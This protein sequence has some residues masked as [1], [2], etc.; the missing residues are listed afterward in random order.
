MPL[1]RVGAGT[2]GRPLDRALAAAPNQP[3]A[4]ALFQHLRARAQ[5][6]AERLVVRLQR[7]ALARVRGVWGHRGCPRGMEQH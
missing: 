4:R 1:P 3:A 2:K 5:R 6:R 7:H